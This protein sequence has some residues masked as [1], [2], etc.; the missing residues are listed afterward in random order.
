MRDEDVKT[1][2]QSRMIQAEERLRDARILLSSGGSGR[3]VVSSA[4]YAGFYAILALLQLAGHTPRKHQGALTLFDLEYVKKG[5]FSTDMSAAIHRLFR[6]RLRD[7]Y[8][9]LDEIDRAEA[10][11]ALKNADEFVRQVRDY[12]AR[13]SI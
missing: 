12:L 11:D 13:N 3:S 7:D 1:L 4:Y 6:M 10:E 9:E 8:I 2:V 5:V